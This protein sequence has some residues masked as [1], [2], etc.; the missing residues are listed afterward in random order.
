M[1]VTWLPDFVMALH[2][3]G[4]WVVPDCRLIQARQYCS[5]FLTALNTVVSKTLFN[6]VFINSKQVAQFLLCIDT[7]V[8]I[9]WLTCKGNFQNLATPAGK[10]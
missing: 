2:C 8:N 6:P 5:V 10:K 4:W 7:V 9:V 3:E 1:L